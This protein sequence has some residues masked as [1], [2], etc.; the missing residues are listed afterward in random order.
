M[1]KA[2]AQIIILEVLGFWPPFSSIFNFSLLRQV[3]NKATSMLCKF[4]LQRGD[5]ST[6]GE[7]FN[8]RGV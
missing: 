3:F 8:Q 2:D 6:K 5:F 1:E 7:G 4:L